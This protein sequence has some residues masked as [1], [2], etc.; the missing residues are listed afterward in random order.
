M[1]KEII[2]GF[3]SFHA[4]FRSFGWYEPGFLPRIGKIG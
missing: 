2:G 4:G 3:G 1:R